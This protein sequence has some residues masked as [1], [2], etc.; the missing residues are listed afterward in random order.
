MA[1]LSIPHVEISL[2]KVYMVVAIFLG[3]KRKSIGLLGISVMV[4]DIIW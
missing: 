4:R 3:G 2:L 1:L